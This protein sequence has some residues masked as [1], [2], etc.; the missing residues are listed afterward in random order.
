MLLPMFGI[1]EVV[2]QNSGAIAEVKL[3]YYGVKRV[4]ATDGSY[5]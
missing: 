1:F 4:T 2:W 3:T 5:T